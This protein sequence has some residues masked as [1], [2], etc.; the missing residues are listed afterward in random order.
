MAP[1]T[2][3]TLLTRDLKHPISNQWC[4]DFG[5]YDRKVV[6]AE[7]DD[8]RDKGWAAAELRIIETSSDQ[9]GI[10]AVVAALN[11]AE[12]AKVARKGRA[13]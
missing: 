10:D 4:P 12:S 2:Y 5:D 9:K 13:P 7:R 3:H 11:A 1:R 8:Y 6:E